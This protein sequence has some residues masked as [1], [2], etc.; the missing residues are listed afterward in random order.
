MPFKWAT[1]LL[2]AII[3]TIIALPCYYVG[4][5]LFH[6]FSF[7]TAELIRAYEYATTRRDN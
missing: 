3:Y 2:L 7:V 5:V 4:L 1:V 6:I